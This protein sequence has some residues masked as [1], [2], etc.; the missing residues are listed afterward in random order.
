[1]IRK[2]GYRFSRRTCGEYRRSFLCAA[3][4]DA[5]AGGVYR[6][7]RR[8]PGPCRKNL[9]NP[10]ESFAGFSNSNFAADG[11]AG[12]QLGSGELQ[13]GRRTVSDAPS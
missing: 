3:K 12:R 8:P 6:R 5:T 11:G 2:S 7:D 10:L 4:T 9:Q 13:S 1:M